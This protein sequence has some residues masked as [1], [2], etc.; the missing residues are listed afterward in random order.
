MNKNQKGFT[1]I[2]LLVVIAI[3]GLLS[4]L[5][6]VSL[7]SARI[8][9]RDAKRQGDAKTLQTAVEM[10]LAENASAPAVAA[11]WQGIASSGAGSLSEYLKSGM[12]EDP[13]TGKMCYC[14]DATT[15]SKYLIIS[16]LENRPTGGVAGDID[17]AITATYDVVGECRC[18]DGNNP[19]AVPH[20]NDDDTGDL[21]GLFPAGSTLC[22]GTL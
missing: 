13:S 7:N 14:R 1:L 8:K 9:A 15:P 21:D 12:P 10:Y 20:C 6:V 22:I 11:T 4:T 18:S 16:Q 17:G 3:I 5:A 2:E 19:T